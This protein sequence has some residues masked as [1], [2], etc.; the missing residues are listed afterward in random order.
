MGWSIGSN[1]FPE[2]AMQSAKP[3]LLT[4]GL[5]VAILVTGFVLAVTNHQSMWD[6]MMGG[7]K[8]GVIEW[9]RH[10]FLPVGVILGLVIWLAS[11]AR[12]RE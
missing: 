5:V 11:R 7:G 4:L 8:R 12:N 9:A 3:F 6:A 1:A 2:V 10:I